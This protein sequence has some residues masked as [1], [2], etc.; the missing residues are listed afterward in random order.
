MTQWPQPKSVYNIQVFLGFVNFYRRFIKGYLHIT[1]PLTELLKTSNKEEENKDGQNQ[2]ARQILP[3]GAREVK[4]TNRTGLSIEKLEGKGM[5]FQTAHI[6]RTQKY[7]YKQTAKGLPFMWTDT[8]EKVFGW[9]K[10]SF[11]GAGILAH[12]YPYKRIRLETNAS[13][14]AIVAILS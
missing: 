9:I 11:S 8:A 12:F 6:E 4:G 3:Q 14:F 7:K 2:P 1:H 10:K 13:K 5:V